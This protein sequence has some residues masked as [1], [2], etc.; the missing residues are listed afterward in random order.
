MGSNKCTLRKEVKNEIAKYIDNEFMNETMKEIVNYIKTTRKVIIDDSNYDE[1]N[2]DSKVEL[3]DNGAFNIHDYMYVKDFLYELSWEGSY[4]EVLEEDED[5]I[6]GKKVFKYE[7][8]DIATVIYEKVDSIMET[9]KGK[10]Y[11]EFKKRYT[12]EYLFNSVRWYK[13]SREGKIYYD[14]DL[15]EISDDKKRSLQEMIKTEVGNAF[16][17]RWGSPVANKVSSLEDKLLLDIYE[18]GCSLLGVE[19]EYYIEFVSEDNSYNEEALIKLMEKNVKEA[20]SMAKGINR[21]KVK[22]INS[23]DSKLDNLINMKIYKTEDHMNLFLE[24]AREMVFGYYK[25]V[26]L[27]GFRNQLIYKEDKI[28]QIIR[29]IAIVENIIYNNY[30]EKNENAPSLEEMEEFKECIP[31]ICLKGLVWASENIYIKNKAKDEIK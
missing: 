11:K 1:S 21:L 10:L 4:V 24:N 2:I 18:R 8:K 9:K 22:V 23:I 19:N 14:I 27:K 28:K 16:K 17:S 25:S 20:V 7:G 29:R 31:W 6:D 30:L 15:E 26:N 13:R 3:K 5:T 12:E